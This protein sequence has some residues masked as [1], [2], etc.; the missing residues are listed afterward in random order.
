MV[1]DKINDMKM[2]LRSKVTLRKTGETEEDSEPPME[3]FNSAKRKEVED[4][5]D[6]GQGDD[7]LRGTSR[8]VAD[9]TMVPPIL[10]AGFRSTSYKS[11]GATQEMEKQ[12]D[13]IL[14]LAAQTLSKTT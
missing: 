11:K 5:K 4:V 7:T 3:A 2:K 12:K 6:M 13:A 14:I 8:T 1:I 10:M 9:V